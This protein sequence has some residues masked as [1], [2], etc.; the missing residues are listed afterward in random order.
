MLS[1]DEQDGTVEYRL[2]DKGVALWPLVRSLMAWG[3][4]FYS[5]AGV[6]R[7]MEIA[8]LDHYATPAVLVGQQ[9]QQLG[10]KQQAR[11]WY[12]RALAFDPGLTNVQAMLAQVG[13]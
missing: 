2:T 13:Q 9:L 7:G 1:R 8:I 5:P 4:A 6:K 3:D 11:E 12:Q 10:F